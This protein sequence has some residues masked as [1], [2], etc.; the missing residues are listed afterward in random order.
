[1]HNQL[2]ILVLTLILPTLVPAQKKKFVLPPDFVEVSGMCIASPD[3]IWWHNDGGDRPRLL[4]SDGRGKVLQRIALPSI[5]NRDWEDISSDPQGYLYLGDF[6]NNLNRRQDLRIYRYHPGTRQ[7]D[8]IVFSYPDQR[9]FPPP[10]AQWNF[11]AEA[12]LWFRDSLH[13][14]SKNRMGAGNY[15]T[16]HYVLPAQ[17]GQHLALLRDSLLL[18]KRVV[19]A[20]AISPSGEQIALLS[21]FYRMTFLGLLPKTRTSI[22]TLSGFPQ[23]NFL[24]GQLKKTRVR[25]PP[26]VPTQYESLD[27]VSAERV[28]IASERTVLF[29]PKAKQVKL[30]TNKTKPTS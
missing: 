27:Y 4:L 15:Y 14:F 26:L 2:I 24:Q 17:P 28:L 21:Y 3:S 19:T 20:A 25:K 13:I 16:K 1:M 29:K 18:P 5:Q 12:L 22:W 10:L 7:L 11:D 8:S 9:S 23:S 6:G 30:K